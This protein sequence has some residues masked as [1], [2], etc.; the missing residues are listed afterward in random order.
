MEPEVIPAAIY[1]RISR[2]RAGGGLGVERQEADCRA[3]AERLGWDVVAVYVDNDI[4]AYS[5]APRPQYRAMLDAVRAGKVRGVLAWHIDRLHR[6]V[7]ELEEFVTLA[8]AHTLRVQSVTAG[9]VDLSTASGRM[10]ARMLGAAAQHEVDH[11]RERMRRAKAQA[12]AE[13]R[14]RGGPRPFGWEA[15]GMTVRKVEADALREAA[16]G[17]LAGRSLASLARELNASGMTTTTGGSWTYG[18]LST[19]LCRPRNAGL[20][21]H[22]KTGRPGMTI[23]GP[24]AWE[25][26]LTE[27]VW[28]AVS[29]VLMDPARRKQRGNERRWLGS[30][31]FRCGVCAAEGVV[32][33]LRV[34]P[35]GAGADGERRYLY[36]C[37]RKAHL[38]ISQEPA[39]LV[40]VGAVR[41][42]LASSDLGRLLSDQATGNDATGEALRDERENLMARLAN[43]E[44]DYIAGHVLGPAYARITATVQ[45]RLDDVA[46]QLAQRVGGGPLA[47]LAA[48]PD[49]VK[50]FLEP[51]HDRLDTQRAILDA[52][53][54]VTIERSMPG[55]DTSA[56]VRV[57]WNLAQA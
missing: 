55:G 18:A 17:V 49:P 44:A 25:P 26:I 15:D 50:A 3:L 22:G 9:T 16:R 52:L 30:G 8:E 53:G 6:R 28:R 14:H 38:T 36:R 10:V 56:R 51:G 27:D 7:S 54:V 45:A 41:G 46:R 34:A 43:V 21:S 35:N 4:S 47:T 42:L 5:G 29:D 40:V 24:G 57:R 37:T 1:A 13:G 32:S 12:A 33:T 31:L 20:V 19:A 39:D 23:A 2:D 11:A 48:T